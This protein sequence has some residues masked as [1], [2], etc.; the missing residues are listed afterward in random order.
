MKY[1][2]ATV[3][4]VGLLAASHAYAFGPI[5]SAGASAVAGAI[6]EQGQGQTQG[7]SQGLENYSAQ[8][9]GQGQKS[10]NSVTNKTGD[11]RSLGVALGQAATAAQG[12]LKGTKFLFGL[13]EWT[14]VSDKCVYFQQAAIAET[15]AATSRD[16]DEANFWLTRSNELMSRAQQ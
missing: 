8:G 7:Q 10:N 13:L 14:D 15:A 11:S 2:L 9:Q 1:V 6:A 16:N 4:A 3:S 12:C 5:A